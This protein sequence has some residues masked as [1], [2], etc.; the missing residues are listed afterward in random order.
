[1]NKKIKS[2]NM[3]K[4]LVY[5]AAFDIAVA[6]THFANYMDIHNLKGNEFETKVLDTINNSLDILI[7]YIEYTEKQDGMV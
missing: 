6:R 2:N 7:E 5:K 4:T 3:T 1:M